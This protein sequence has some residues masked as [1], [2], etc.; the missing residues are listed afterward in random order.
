[1][2]LFDGEVAVTLCK[3]T[4]NGR[5]CCVHFWETIVHISKGQDQSFYYDGVESIDGLRMN[6]FLT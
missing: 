4:W 5:Y 2:T 6:S 3:S 1:M